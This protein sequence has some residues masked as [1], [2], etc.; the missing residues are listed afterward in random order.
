MD[1][2]FY[3]YKYFILRLEYLRKE[4]ET[5]E[6]RTQPS[7]EKASMACMQPYIKSDIVVMHCTSVL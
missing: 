3:K 5:Y 2:S 7:W 4:T 1:T 6:F